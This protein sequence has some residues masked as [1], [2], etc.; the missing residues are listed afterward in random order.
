MTTFERRC[1]VELKEY[2]I[3]E[4]RLNL[5]RIFYI[6]V[7]NSEGVWVNYTFIL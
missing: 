3:I 7:M 6:V 4:K 5:N 1:R 2:E